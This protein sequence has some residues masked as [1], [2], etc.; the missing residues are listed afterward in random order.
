MTLTD[1]VLQGL[2]E[3]LIMVSAAFGIGIFLGLGLA[4]L[5][6][7]TSP[8][9]ILE[10]KWIHQGLGFGINS[11]RSIPYIILTVLLF[12]VTRFLVH[13]SIGTIA[14]IVPLAISAT[15]LVART[16]EESFKMVPKGLIEAGVSMGASRLQIITHFVFPEAF[17][18]IISGLTLVVIN[19]I[20]IS[21]MA[22]TVGGG[23][24][25]DLAIRFGYQRY[26][27]Q[28]LFIIVIILVILVQLTQW[29]GENLARF[30][31][32]QKGKAN[33]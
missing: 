28:L 29:V 25:G 16:I 31:R 20:G 22:G 26:D 3:T 4:T 18:N 17:P 1:L 7:L 10:S 32:K 5:L 21:A 8:G 14:S 12:P 27:I 9:G 23:G 19:L 6:F 13:S 30:A 24:L 2:V 33:A 15:L 11:L